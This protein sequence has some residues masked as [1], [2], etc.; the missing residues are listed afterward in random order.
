VLVR[1][2]MAA[3]G[4]SYSATEPV[5]QLRQQ[6]N[7]VSDVMRQNVNKVIERGEKLE[8]LQE[9]SEILEATSNQFQQ[10]ATRVKKKM[11]WQNFKM[12]IILA[13][14]II[15]IIAVLVVVI[16]ASTGG[17]NS[18]GGGGEPPVTPTTKPAIM[19]RG[20]PDLNF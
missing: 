3:P 10:Q 1:N 13:V 12:K 20:V 2:T 19:K 9:R 8:D 14:V 18:S 7:D 16:I 5:A 4:M 11:W 15:V 17:F 6:V